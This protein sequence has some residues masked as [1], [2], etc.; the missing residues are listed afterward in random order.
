VAVGLQRSDGL[1]DA[2]HFAPAVLVQGRQRRS[3]GEALQFKRALDAGGE[4]V[5]SEGL[6]RPC[7]EQRG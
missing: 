4:R 6:L 3:D 1:E 5:L 7:L 2:A